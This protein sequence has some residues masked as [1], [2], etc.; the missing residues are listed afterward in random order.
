MPSQFG[1]IPIDDEQPVTGGSRFGGIPVNDDISAPNPTPAPPKVAPTAVD[2]PSAFSAKT[3][4]P[5]PDTTGAEPDFK[6]MGKSFVSAASQAPAFLGDAG[7]FVV[8]NLTKGTARAYQLAGGEISP[9]MAKAITNMHGLYASDTYKQLGIPVHDPK[10]FSGALGTV[11][12]QGAGLLAAEKSAPS[13]INA[14]KSIP[15]GAAL[16]Y[17]GALGTD[18][19][20]D[21]AAQSDANWKKAG[22]TLTAA[23]NG[24]AVLTPE[25]GQ[26]ILQNVKSAVG[27]LNSR[28]PHTRA[29]LA[30][31]ETKVNAGE[32]T[33]SDIHEFRQNFG[34]VISDNT[35]SKID[36]GG[37]TTDGQRAFAAK[38]AISDSIDDLANNPRSFSAGTPESAG[39]LKQGINEW[40]QAS[41]YDR[42]AELIKKSEG[43]ST[44]IKRNFTNFVNNDKNLRGFNESEIAALKDAAAR[45]TLEKIERGIGTFGLDLGKTKNIALPAITSGSSAVVPGG[46]P[47]AATGTLLRQTGKYA[48]RGK[49]QNALDAVMGRE[50]A[51]P[52]PQPPKPQLLL[53][54]PESS[55]NVLVNTAGDAVQYPNGVHD[56]KFEAQQRLQNAQTQQNMPVRAQ[57]ELGAAVAQ[58]GHLPF[59]DENGQRLLNARQEAENKLSGNIQGALTRAKTYPLFSQIEKETQIAKEADMEDFI[60]S[61]AETPEKLIEN[62]AQK[63]QDGGIPLGNVGEA[64]VRLLQDKRGSVPMPQWDKLYQAAKNWS[65]E[66]S[67]GAYL[68]VNTNNNQQKQNYNVNIPQISPQSNNQTLPDIS[69]FAKAESGNNPNAKNSNST[70][71]GLYQFT[72]KT[73]ADM[74]SRYGKQTGIGLQDKNNPQAQ[75]IMTKLLAQDNIRSLQKTLG[76]LPTKGELYMAHVLG[77]NGAA[78]LI[79]ADPSKEAIMLF[80]R[81]VFD[82]N[83][84]IFFQGKQPRSV[85][86]VYQILNQK[87][88]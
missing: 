44:A 48:A 52:T 17:K 82:A 80:P 11:A 54:A 39:L 56:A 60:K 70:A 3:G 46:L 37:L 81:Q 14:A 59:N 76:R 41:R 12:G 72:N 43:D 75:T 9:E 88:A 35:K 10:G 77:S 47:L 13:I 33:L 78:K 19:A 29:E 40:A 74:V 22:E 85:A 32:L 18:S 36:G 25:A 31:F 61:T 53:P 62:M 79:N 34:D 51:T 66:I 27:N 68:G 5:V 73:W 6:E 84:N 83:R 71:S 8:D 16:R 1:G 65:P 86:D 20:D 38:N 45:G 30:D 58:N 69:N 64:L 4:L 50:I 67:K 21:I 63:F 26:T 23:H 7:S 2:H 49:A 87:V 24:G 15:E 28:S 55:E 42:I 57:S